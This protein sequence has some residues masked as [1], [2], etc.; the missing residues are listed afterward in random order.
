MNAGGSLD[1]AAI[2]RLI[3]R[4]CHTCVEGELAAFGDLWAEDAELVLRGTVIAGR[5]AICDALIAKQPPER[6]GRHM[7]VNIV[8]DLDGD[9]ARALSDFMFFAP[10]PEHGLVLRFVGRYADEFVRADAGWQFCRRE[11][12][13][14]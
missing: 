7:T 14:F 13:M 9:T 1:S 8:I 3:A 6:R 12:Q 2:G 4:Y 5:D 10:D 11:I